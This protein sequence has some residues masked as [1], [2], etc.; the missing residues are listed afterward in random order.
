MTLD[1]IAEI[2]KELL[3]A[4]YSPQRGGISGRENVKDRRP[5]YRNSSEA[6]T[7]AVKP[8]TGEFRRP[9]L[10]GP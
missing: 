10:A 2:D 1:E 8:D 3:A 6:D 5:C 4:R 7:D 9:C